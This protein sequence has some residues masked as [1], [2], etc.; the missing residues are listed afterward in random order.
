MGS[1]GMYT[2]GG[3]FYKRDTYSNEGVYSRHAAM[4]I[5]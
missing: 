5:Y 1:K 3:D 4:R 2:K